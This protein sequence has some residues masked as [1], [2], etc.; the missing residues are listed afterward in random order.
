MKNRKRFYGIRIRLIT[1]F[2]LLAILPLSIAGLYGI[3]YSVSSL[4]DITINRLEYEISSKGND[5]ERFLQNVH[6]HVLYLSRSA[7]LSEMIERGG[8]GADRKKLENHF[9][10]FS[11]AHPYYN[12]IRYINENGI[13]IARVDSDGKSSRV[14]AQD[15]LQDKSDRYYF[16]DSV[17][18]PEGECYVSPLDFNIEWGKIEIPLKPV[19]RIATPVFDGDHINRGIIIINLYGSYII[20]QMQKMS[21]AK[22]G[23][24]FLTNQRGEYLAHS[25]YYNYNKPVS[26]PSLLT[27]NIRSLSDDYSKSL[28]SKILSKQK[29][30]EVLRDKII[31]YSPISTGDRVS[32]SFWVL[33]L[34]YPK[35]II[36][37][38]ISRLK[39]AFLTI[40]GIAILTSIVIGILMARHFTAPISE[41]LKDVDLIAGGDFSHRLNLNSRDELEQLADRFNIMAEKLEESRARLTNWNEDLKREVESRTKELKFEKNR[42]ESILTCAAE[43]II[44]ADENDNVIMINPAAEKILGIH[45]EDIIGKTF[46]QCHIEPENVKKMLKDS[47]TNKLPIF[48]ISIS[49]SKILDINVVAMKIDEKN[50]GSMMIFRDI[51]DRHRLEESQRKLEKQM[52]QA[53]KLASLSVLSAGI[54][55]EIG[56]PLAAIKTVVQ[57]MEE[58]L[59]LS[60]NQKRFPE[61][62]I[63]EVDRLASFLKT[64][65]AFAK[66]SEKHIATIDIVKVIRDVLFWMDKEASNRGINI[67]Y[68]EERNLPAIRADLQ[69][70][71]QVLINILINAVH[72][73]PPGGKINIT[74]NYSDETLTSLRLTK[75]DE[76]TEALPPLTPPYK[77]GETL[78]TPPLMTRGV[79]LIPPLCKGRLGGV[80]VFSD[81]K[82][83]IK[84]SDTGSGIPDDILEKIFDPFFTTK[85]AGTGLGLSIAQKIVQAHGGEIKVSGK[86]G[87]GASFEIILPV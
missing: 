30:T 75:G 35:E 37:E 71:Q 60:G 19:V 62:I 73:T 41:F 77:G 78:I 85:P 61:R 39:I 2:L 25:E 4:A 72:A 87:E 80:E 56:N 20:E 70:I 65:S 29:G 24:T 22:R 55:H 14:I 63:M 76:N 59:L 67:V 49:G 13:E 10:N 68:R 40:G 38:P 31:S 16:T 1:A 66:P 42:L 11:M 7:I 3:Y 83:M 45:R 43:G 58:E 64:F 17:K 6:S 79:S 27:A 5:I 86:E 52:L 69:Q 74:T 36:F 84:I 26:D 12:Q 50:L 18:Y 21:I 82:I 9:L 47:E 15:R 28:I 44:V 51:T 8:G 32:N 53:E 34:A 54:Y 48:T 57:A 46:S 23:I 33:S 81:Q